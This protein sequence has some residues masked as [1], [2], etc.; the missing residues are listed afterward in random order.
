MSMWAIYGASTRD[1]LTLD[2][3]PVVHDSREELEWLLPGVRAVPVTL[4]DLRQ[5]SPLGAIWLRDHPDIKELGV[6][7]PLRREEWVA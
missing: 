2:G 4:G 6:T 5:R 1:I 7:F 3:R